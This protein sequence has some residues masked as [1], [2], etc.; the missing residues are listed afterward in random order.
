MSPRAIVGAAKA[1]GIDLIAVTDHNTAGMVAEVGRAARGQGVEFLPGI[2]LQTQEE[3]HLLGYFDD[4]ATCL[5]FAAEIYECLPNRSNDPEL[6]GDQVIV[7]ADETIVAVEPRLLV[8]ALRLSLEEAV[9]R[10]EAH[11]GLAVPAHVD[12]APYG[13][14]AQLGFFPDGLDFA[15]VE[16]DGESLPEPRCGS[17]LMWG[18]DAHAPE[19]IGS[20][21]TVFRMNAPTIEEMRRAAAGES[22]RSVTVRQRAEKRAAR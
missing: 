14:I 20:R 2:E 18:S 1:K 13:L 6:F 12:R 19:A 5:R 4:V 9:A 8:N 21:V 7:D 17:A 15:F 3:V 11:G 16:A 22:G 10:V